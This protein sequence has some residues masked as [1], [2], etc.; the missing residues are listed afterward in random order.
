MRLLWGILVFVNCVSTVPKA[1]YKV[2]PPQKVEVMEFT[3]I[4]KNDSGQTVWVVKE[5]KRD[6]KIDNVICIIK[7][8]GEYWV[9]CKGYFAGIFNKDTDFIYLKPKEEGSK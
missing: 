2:I 6:R 4:M 7:T 9:Y 8:N 1:P 3:E 5:L